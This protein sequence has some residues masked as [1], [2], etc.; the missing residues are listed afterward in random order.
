MADFR[1]LLVAAALSFAA[2][3]ALAAS[4]L[5]CDPDLGPGTTLA[6]LQ[7]HYG[8][9]NVV[10]GPV[11]GA[12]G[13][14]ITA[15]TIY[16]NDPE[17]SFIVYWWDEEKQERLAGYSIPASGTGPGGLKMGMSI[18]DVEAING[19]PFTLTGFY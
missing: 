15:T 16:P 6:D 13:E 12:E 7:T 4:E 14:T 8:K 3:P 17:K 5:A 1:P 18:A 19:G 9:D 2:L 11:D 10:T